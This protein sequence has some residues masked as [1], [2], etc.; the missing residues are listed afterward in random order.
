[1]ELLP[2][3]ARPHGLVTPGL[4]RLQTGRMHAGLAAV[5]LLAALLGHAAV[6]EPK[7]RP[8]DSCRSAGALKFGAEQRPMQRVRAETRSTRVKKSK[9]S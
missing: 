6:A 2:K 5:A 4:D 8:D 1:M 9:W 3:P 7:Q